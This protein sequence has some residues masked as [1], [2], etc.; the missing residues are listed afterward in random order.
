MRGPVQR[1]HHLGPVER[2]RKD[3][4]RALHAAKLVIGQAAL[5]P[6][7][8]VSGHFLACPVLP[9]SPTGANPIGGRPLR[10][11]MEDEEKEDAPLSLRDGASS[12]KANERP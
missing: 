7:R 8:A 5:S 6:T 10:P 11:F 2:D 1:I 3:G 12:K 9:D 4:A